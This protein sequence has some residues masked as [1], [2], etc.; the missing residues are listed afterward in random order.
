VL[1]QEALFPMPQEARTSDDYW[2]PKWIFDALGVEFDLDVACPPDG[3]AHTPAK[4]YYTQETDALVSPW[5]GTVFMNPPFSKITPWVDKFIEHN[6][7]VCLLPYS[8]SKWFNRLWDELDGIVSIPRGKAAFVQGDIFMPCFIGTL[9]LKSTKALK[10][11]G[12]G[13]VR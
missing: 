5:F 12:I 11:S 9:G 10:Q 13:R 1:N 8:K 7:G 4:A 2:T 3:P 6:D